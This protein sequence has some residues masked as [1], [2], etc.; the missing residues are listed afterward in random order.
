MKNWIKCLLK[1]H[2]YELRYIRKQPEQ[3]TKRVGV[4]CHR[5]GKEVELRGKGDA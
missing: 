1:G 3:G 2:L 5:C 4:I